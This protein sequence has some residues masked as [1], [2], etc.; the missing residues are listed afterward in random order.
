ML[1]TKGSWHPETPRTLLSRA[2]K[3][4]EREMEQLRASLQREAKKHAVSETESHSPAAGKGPPKDFLRAAQVLSAGRED[5]QKLR[6]DQEALTRVRDC[7]W[8]VA[9]G[10]AQ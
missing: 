4:W 3:G 10:I 1:A 6:L 9:N 7:V 5:M 2:Q 8:V